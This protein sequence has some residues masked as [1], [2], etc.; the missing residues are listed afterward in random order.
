MFAN[1]KLMYSILLFVS[2]SKKSF[3][4]LGKV[5]SRSGDTI[6]RML[7]GSAESFHF[8]QNTAIS[9]FSK[10]SHL[11]ILIDDTLIRKIHSK[12]IEGTGSFF[13]T[14]LGR[15]IMAFR[16]LVCVVTDGK[17]TLP[18]SGKFLFAKELMTA[19]IESKEDILKQI[20]ATAERLFPNIALTTVADGAF[21]T[22]TF[23]S[24]AANEKKRV[25]VRMHSNRKVVYRGE[26]IAIRDIEKLQPKGRRMACTIEAT[27]HNIPLYITAQRRIDKHG[28][29][30]IVYQAATFKAK[31][32]EHVRTYK[33]RWNIEK[34]FRFIKQKVGLQDCYSTSL[35]TQMDHVASVFVSYTFAELERKYKKLNSAEESAR[36]FK[37]RKVDFLNRHFY[38]LTQIFG[39]T[40]A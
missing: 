25:E 34:F 36:A 6:K 37:S 1:T 11:F 22:K 15:R 31:P 10:R 12:L 18:L 40:Y 17:Y 7:P 9:F 21:A 29:E 23:L 39:Y 28:E 30:T 35:E 19:P 14:S 26:K 24:W 2:T 13:D 3:E 8:L 33:I 32:S 38:R 27:W 16:L 5:I 4:A 20:V